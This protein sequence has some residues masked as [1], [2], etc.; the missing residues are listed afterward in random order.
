MAK[1]EDEPQEEEGFVDPQAKL[2][3]KCSAKPDC[4]KLSQRLEECNE[5]V[6][7]RIKTSETCHEEVVDLFHCVDHCVA[8]DLF[9]HLK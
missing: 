7:G 3:E 4:A 9:H 5:R 6:R 2:R 8:K 1:H